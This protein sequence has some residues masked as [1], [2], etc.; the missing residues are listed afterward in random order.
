MAG[1]RTATDATDTVEQL[2]EA[3]C[4]RDAPAELFHVDADGLITVARVRLLELT[5]DALL[6]D[7]PIYLEDDIHVPASELLTLHVA[8]G[9]R[10]YQCPT[11]IID[12]DRMIRLNARQSVPGIA[13]R[14]PA[15]LTLSQRRSHLRVSTVGYEPI[16]VD[17]VRACDEPLVACPLDATPTRGWIVDLSV[18]GIS[19]LIDHRVLRQ[20]VIGDR[21]YLSFALPGVEEPF[22]MLGV[23]RH[24]RDVPSSESIR[25]A[26]AF[27]RWG[28]RRMTPD[29]HRLSRF[30]ADHER[31]ML[32]QRK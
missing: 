16:N 32:R 25:L 12:E 2:L 29:Q 1:A 15:E 8:V 13:L 27:R 28:D 19:V 30:V 6:A 24:A 31:R 5:D 18:G 4:A 11:A 17:V 3:A 9:G 23:I 10:R 22:D 7:A 26:M 14:R 21:Y 20:V